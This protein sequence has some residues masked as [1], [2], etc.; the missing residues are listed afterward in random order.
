[1]SASRAAQAQRIDFTTPTS[2]IQP[3]MAQIIVDEDIPVAFQTVDGCDIAFRRRQADAS[4]AAR[5]GIVWLG[6]FKS[7]MQSTKA[8]FFNWQ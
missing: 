2:E 4:Q 5:P 1:M 3:Q 6:G 7:D 8:L